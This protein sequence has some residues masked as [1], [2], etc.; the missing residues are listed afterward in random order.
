MT[1]M[2]MIMMMA[3]RINTITIIMSMAGDHDEAVEVRGNHDDDV[4]QS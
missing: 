4:Q 3:V 1:I 2:T